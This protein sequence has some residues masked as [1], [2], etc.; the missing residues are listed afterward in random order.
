MTD[1][2]TKPTI[3]FVD[4]EL[5]GAGPG[6]PGH[7]VKGAFTFVDSVVTICHPKTGEPVQDQK[8]SQYTFKLS[9]PTNTLEDA[10]I[11]A[12]RLTKDF[13]RAL[14]GDNPGGPRGPL[15]Y[16]PRGWC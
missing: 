6:D 1:Q 16:P 15:R 7:T 9:P 2:K 10:Y 13:R 12:K 8:G 4:V 3:Y 5:K 14:R 11:H